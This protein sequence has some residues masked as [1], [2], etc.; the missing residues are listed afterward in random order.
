LK[1]TSENRW[2]SLHQP[3][4]TS[5]FSEYI[6]SNNN[7]SKILKIQTFLHTQRLANNV[8]MVVSH[9]NLLQYDNVI[10]LQHPS[11]VKSGQCKDGLVHYSREIVLNG[12]KI[13]LENGCDVNI[14]ELFSRQGNGI[15]NHGCDVMGNIV[16]A[17]LKNELDEC[18]SSSNGKLGVEFV[19]PNDDGQ[20]FAVNSKYVILSLISR[21]SDD[22][23]HYCPNLDDSELFARHKNSIV[24]EGKH[25]G[26]KGK[27]FAHGIHASFEQHPDGTPKS[28]SEYATKNKN[29]PRYHQFEAKMD[30]IKHFILQCNN[31]IDNASGTSLVKQSATNTRKNLDLGMMLN[32]L[33]KPHNGR[34]ISLFPLSL[35]GAS[36]TFP[37][38]NVCLNASTDIFHTENDQGYTLIASPYQISQADASFVFQLSSKVHMRTRL[39]GGT[40]ILF[41]ARLVTHRQE[42]VECDLSGPFWNVGCYANRR[43]DQ[44]TFSLL[45]RQF[46]LVLCNLDKYI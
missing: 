6:H 1:L 9:G 17:V 15:F 20:T 30:S 44:H 42:L 2:K 34:P 3:I 29:D 26:S 28:I 36:L 45:R 41:N 46:D 39:R 10:L 7:Q 24:K 22:C 31:E 13:E 40:I 16:I 23:N 5:S 4:T 12:I 19:Y 27:Y 35:S 32:A 21:L 43:F 25:F 38:I 14:Y 33:T 11:F 18:I 37:S 8:A